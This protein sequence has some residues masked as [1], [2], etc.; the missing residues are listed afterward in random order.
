M[1]FEA[2][3]TNPEVTLRDDYDPYNISDPNKKKSH[4]ANMAKEQIY[5]VIRVDGHRV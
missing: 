1:T 5:I 2:F 4:K 3:D